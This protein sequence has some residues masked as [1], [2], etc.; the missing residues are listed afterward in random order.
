MDANTIIGFLCF[1]A[2]FIN[3]F[4]ALLLWIRGKTK[5]TFLLGRTAF[6]SALYNF[7]LAMLR[8]SKAMLRFS[9]N[10]KSAL[11]WSRATWLGLLIIPESLRFIYYFT[12]R[13]KNFK[14]KVFI[15]YLP[16]IIFSILA[17]TTPFFAK[18]IIFT[19]P[20]Y[21]EKEG[22]L[23]KVGW[24]Y[25]AIGSVVAFY[26]LFKDY[27]KS[28]G[29][30]KLQIKYFIIGVSIY[31]GSGVL[32]AGIL[33]I[34]NPQIFNQY[35]DLSGISSVFWVGLSTIAIFQESLFGIKLILTEIL[36]SIM[37]VF[38]IIL[39]FLM[40]TLLLKSLIISFLFLFSIFAYLLIRYTHQEIHQKKILEEKV[41]ERTEKL[42]N[43][44][45]QLQKAKEELEK[46]YNQVLIEKDRFEKFYK[47]TLGREMRIIELKKKVR[48][49]EREI[50]ELKKK[51]KLMN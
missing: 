1:T 25:V 29:V 32:F 2:T 44:Y 45:Q 14:F 38:L 3:L 6:F 10:P 48:E 43:A 13:T 5:N 27:L 39:P 16:A 34:L 24:G 50:D 23:S 40:P 4:F 49:K 19:K 41:K 8:F 9:N 20:F 18:E 26:Y 37:G 42:E 7:T 35:V 30:K 17:L 51:E 28:Q 21:E 22:P 47:T 12:E 36:I 33:P 11:F 46:A 31:A 15:W